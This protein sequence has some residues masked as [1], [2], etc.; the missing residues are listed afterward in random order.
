MEGTNM[1][2]KVLCNLVCHMQVDGALKDLIDE[3]FTYCDGCLFPGTYVDRIGYLA[4]YVDHVKRYCEFYNKELVDNPD[5]MVRVFFDSNKIECFLG[6]GKKGWFP[7]LTMDIIEIKA[8]YSIDS[9]EPISIK[10]HPADDEEEV[11]VD[12]DFCIDSPLVVFWHDGEIDYLGLRILLHHKLG[13]VRNGN[14]L[15]RYVSEEKV[16]PFSK[17]V[18]YRALLKYMVDKKADIVSIR[19][20]LLNSEA[21]YRVMSCLPNHRFVDENSEK[22]G[23]HE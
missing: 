19:C 10:V 4:D 7:L 23:C 20:F 16:I 6:N 8:V 11:L 21:I 12:E 2:D 1:N 17:K 9:F 5:A 15:F 13:F 3:L 22:G 14:R 18:L